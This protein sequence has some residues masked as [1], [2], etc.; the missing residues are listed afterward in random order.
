MRVIHIITRL[1]V[2][3]AQENTIASVL[4]LKQRFSHDVQLISGP[5]CGP[6]GSLE[7]LVSA[8]PGLLTVIPTL[9]RPVSPWRDAQALS[10]LTALLRERAPEIVH[11]HSGKAGILGRMAA[12]RARVPVII[13]TIHGPSFGAFQSPLANFVFRAS[14]R[15]AAGF[16]THFVTVAQAMTE[17]YLAAGIGAREQFT[18]IFSGFPIEPFLVASNSLPLRAQLGLA[19]DDLVVGKVARLFHLTGHEDLFAIAPGLAAE[20]PR[21]KFLLVGD[22]PWRSRFEQMAARQNLG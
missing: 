3:G 18:R 17:Q 22:G 6:E 12:R 13:H 19:P 7:P 8:E 2:G 20:F 5:T 4:G 11:T 21:L 16:T 14:E 1:I 15:F 10:Q 9:V